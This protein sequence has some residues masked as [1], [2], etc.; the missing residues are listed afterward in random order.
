MNLG[1]RKA[2][3]M[4]LAPEIWSVLSVLELFSCGGARQSRAVILPGRHAYACAA[5]ARISLSV[6]R[7]RPLHQQNGHVD[8]E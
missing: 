7:G 3:A 4:S 1:L 2:M 6:G 5:N 8:L